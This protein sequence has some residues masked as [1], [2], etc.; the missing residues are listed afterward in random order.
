MIPSAASSG[1]YDVSHGRPRCQ[2]AAHS[3]AAAAD[4]IGADAAENL[5]AAAEIFGAADE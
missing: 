5:S 1:Q 4:N 2:L 3:F